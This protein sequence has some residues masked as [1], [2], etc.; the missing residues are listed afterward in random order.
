MDLSDSDMGPKKI[1][2]FFF[3]FFNLT[4]LIVQTMIFRI[5]RVIVMIHIIYSYLII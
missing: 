1:V 2:T 3:F 4:I 5:S